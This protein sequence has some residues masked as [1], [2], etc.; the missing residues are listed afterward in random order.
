[1]L[2]Y[3]H[4]CLL[5]YYNS[6]ISLIAIIHLLFHYYYYLISVFVLLCVFM[7]PFN[8][9]SVC[10]DKHLHA[11]ALHYYQQSGSVFAGIGL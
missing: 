6:L 11:C 3:P 9:D 1:M 7:R 10:F 4:V 5:V 2:G 8:Y